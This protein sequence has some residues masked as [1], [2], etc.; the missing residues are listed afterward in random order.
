MLLLLTACV[1]NKNHYND[2]AYEIA[3]SDR[4]EDGY[5]DISDGGPTDRA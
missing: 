1:I 2:V 5:A 3:T 4:D